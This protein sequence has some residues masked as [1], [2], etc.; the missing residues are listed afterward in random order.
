MS[1]NESGDCAN[2]KQ[3]TFFQMYAREEK[4]RAAVSGFI[5]M[6]CRGQKQ[7]VCVRKRVGAQVGGPQRVPANMLP[8]GLPLFGT[9]SG[10][11]PDEVKRAS[12]KEPS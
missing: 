7:D 8:T 12:R 1:Y 3:C 11:W 2:M 6:Y 10:D 4:Y 9:T 5:R